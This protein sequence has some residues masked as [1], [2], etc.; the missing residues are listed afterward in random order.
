MCAV[1]VTKDLFWQNQHFLNESPLSIAASHVADHLAW[2]LTQPNQTQSV[3]A[4]EV[5]VLVYAAQWRD[6]D[7]HDRTTAEKFELLNDWMGDSNF[8]I[9][10]C[11]FVAGAGVLL[12][13]AATY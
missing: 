4:A 2:D 11:C 3:T 12:D 6:L 10:D 7:R 5:C 8:T 9:Q 13:K 1:F